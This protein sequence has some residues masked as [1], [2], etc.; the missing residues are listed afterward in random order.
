MNLNILNQKKTKEKENTKLLEGILKDYLNDYFE[1]VE[2]DYNFGREGFTFLAKEV[3]CRKDILKKFGIPLELSTG[4]IKVI[5]LTVKSLITLK[6]FQMEVSDIDI[7]IETIHINKDY[8]KN[9][10]LYRQK[11]LNEWEI[12]HKK[13]FNDMTKNS[14]LEKFIIDRLIPIKFDI[15]NI[16]IT[17]NDTISSKKKIYQI[18]LKIENIHSFG[19]NQN[20]KEIDSTEND[21]IIYRVFDIKGLSLKINKIENEKN[22]VFL[23][24]IISDLDLNIKG[25][26]LQTYKTHSLKSTPKISATT[27]F[28]SPLIINLTIQNINILQNLVNYLT[29]IKK[30]EQYWIN[31]PEFKEEGKL[32]PT[33]SLKWFLYAFRVLRNEIRNNKRQKHELSSLIEKI[34][35]MEKYIQFYKE[36]HKLIIAPWIHQKDH[37]VELINLENK[38]SFDDIIYCR[39]LAFV[40][41]LTEGRAFCASGEVGEGYKPF[42]H[43]WEFYVNDLRTKW[44]NKEENDVKTIKLSDNERRE[45]MTIWKNDRD[46]ILMSY[47]KGEPNHPFDI[48]LDCSIEFKLITLNFMKHVDYYTNDTCKIA[49]KNYIYFYKE[50]FYKKLKT[51]LKDLDFVKINENINDEVIE[52]CIKDEIKIDNNLDSD[53]DDINMENSESS[54]SHEVRSYSNNNV[55]K[56]NNFY[57]KDSS[58]EDSVIYIDEI[59]INKFDNNNN[60]N[61]NNINNNIN[62]NNDSSFE[63]NNN[64]IYQTSTKIKKL[65][66]ILMK[67]KQKETK[68]VFKSIFSIYLFSSNLSFNSLRNGKSELH[69]TIGAFNFLDHNLTYI[70]LINLEKKGNIKNKLNKT[71]KYYKDTNSSN[72]DFDLNSNN[73]N[74]IIN[75]SSIYNAK[76]NTFIDSIS[77]FFIDILKHKKLR[78]RILEDNFKDENFF[79]NQYEDYFGFK[80]CEAQG[81]GITTL[82][83]HYDKIIVDYLIKLNIFS[84]TKNKIKKFINNNLQKKKFKE[85]KEEEQNDLLKKILIK[86]YNKTINYENKRLYDPIVQEKFI[87]TM[88]SDFNKMFELQSINVILY[89]LSE[90]YLFYLHENKYI[91]CLEKR[92]ESIQTFESLFLEINVNK[93]GR[94]Y[95]NFILYKFEENNRKESS[96]TTNDNTNNN[97]DFKNSNNIENINVNNNNN[98]HENISNINNNIN[99]DNNNNNNDNDNPIIQITGIINH[100]IKIRITNELISEF[101]TLQPE[102]TKYENNSYV[103]NIL[104]DLTRSYLEIFDD[105]R[106]LKVKRKV[107]EELFKQFSNIKNKNSDYIYN[108]DNENNSENN[109]DENESEENESEEN[110]N[111]N[112]QND[113]NYSKYPIEMIYLDNITQYIKTLSN[114]QTKITFCFNKEL[115]LSYNLNIHIFDKIYFLEKDKI[116]CCKILLNDIEF[117]KDNLVSIPNKD[118]KINLPNNF[119]LNKI[120]KILFYKEINIGEIIITFNDNFPI[121]KTDFNALFINSLI[122]NTL[123]VSDSIIDAHSNNLEI[124]IYPCVFQLIKIFSNL[125]YFGLIYKMIYNIQKKNNDNKDKNNHWSIIENNFD[126]FTNNVYNIYFNKNQNDDLS[127]N[128]NNNN[129]SEKSSNNQKEVSFEENNKIKPL[130]Y[131]LERRAKSIINYSLGKS[132]KENKGIIVNVFSTDKLKKNIFSSSTNKNNINNNIEPFFN[133]KS[134]F[135]IFH[136]FRNLFFEKNEIWLCPIETTQNYF[137]EKIS[138]ELNKSKPLTFSSN[139]YL[140]CKNFVN[141]VKENIKIHNIL[142]K[143]YPFDH[144]CKIEG[145]NINCLFNNTVYFYELDEK[146]RKIYLENFNVLLDENNIE[147]DSMYFSKM[148]IYINEIKIICQINKNKDL[149]DLY[150]NALKIFNESSCINF[151]NYFNEKV[152]KSLIIENNMKKKININKNLNNENKKL[153]KI[154]ISDQIVK[155]N[156]MSV[157]KFY[158]EIIYKNLNNYNEN[159]ISNKNNLESENEEEEF[160]EKENINNENTK[161]LGFKLNIENIKYNE[162]DTKEKQNNNKKITKAKFLIDNFYLN[163]TVPKNFKNEKDFFDSENRIQIND[164]NKILEIF[165]KMKNNKLYKKESIILKFKDF[166]MKLLGKTTV[167]ISINNFFKIGFLHNNKFE[168]ILSFIPFGLS[169]EDDEQIK[170]YNINEIEID[171]NFKKSFQIN[172]TEILNKNIDYEIFKFYDSSPFSSFSKMI[173]IIQTTFEYKLFYQ[174]NIYFNVLLINFPNRI[175]HYIYYLKNWLRIYSHMLNKV[176]PEIRQLALNNK[177]IKNKIN[178]I[179]NQK[180]NDEID[181]FPENNN[182]N[183][184]IDVP[185]KGAEGLIAKINLPIIFFNLSQDNKEFSNFIFYK[186]EINLIKNDNNEIILN[187]NIND[188]N[189]RVLDCNCKN[190]IIKNKNFIED[191]SNN[192]IIQ[193]EIII[194]DSNS[195]KNKKN[196]QNIKHKKKITLQNCSL[197]GLFKYINEVTLFLDTNELCLNENPLKS[198][199]FNLLYKEKQKTEDY[200]FELNNLHIIIPESS[201]SANYLTIFFKKANVTIN[202]LIDE[203]KTI[204]IPTSKDQIIYVID[205]KSLYGL[206]SEFIT[207]ENS[208]FEINEQQKKFFKEKNS[209]FLFNETIVDVNDMEIISK[210]DNFEK[211]FGIIGKSI[212]FIHNLKS[213]DVVTRLYEYFFKKNKQKNIQMKTGMNVNLYDINANI[214]MSDIEVINHFVDNNIDEKSEIFPEEDSIFNNIDLDI[215]LNKNSQINLDMFKMFNNFFKESNKLEKI[216]EKLPGYNNEITYDTEFSIEDED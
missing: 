93:K 66:T 76:T 19:S 60:N 122:K 2:F 74:N 112:N 14:L 152:F 120:C 163:L 65:N 135:V 73:N 52:K 29:K 188:F 142:S 183:V 156:E 45:L 57:E 133:F 23:G 172:F 144:V 109:S 75:N 126:R 160:E 137:Y 107:F 201:K 203:L 187:I 138:I 154:I 205:K 106:K 159:N 32:N 70:T 165:K 94:E 211:N 20:W 209:L 103:G 67:K 1:N 3:E 195:L 55:S 124:N 42:V 146:L 80:K 182:N 77:Y 4:K 88:V 127:N 24:T 186:N 72:F 143:N 113:N 161:Y 21:D 114:Q 125:N 81:T 84:N 6:N 180:K 192:N 199:M 169:K 105:F 207:I 197:V 108:N 61:N 167:N 214:T 198:D 38:M 59:K 202:N 89:V 166:S 104:N 48:L 181:N 53:D 43:L 39:E 58:A 49:L 204:N 34:I 121:I 130:Q 185:I 111:K 194:D 33:D 92:L 193:M 110:N 158:F 215:K 123:F 116:S 63:N 40:E 101:Q 216:K 85:I 129:N 176:H 18:L 78:E 206:Q 98:N 79:F 37:K 22:Y 17:I 8:K 7:K 210:I 157:N 30:V 139:E 136:K 117:K 27:V 68:N 31:R 15:H 12:K 99:F 184:D 134:N 147:K 50:K 177:N 51:D 91:N 26:I 145:L 5:K 54:K 162:N 171:K 64:E 131:Y 164:L 132:H 13:I 150:F 62:I 141:S 82:K 153:K 95:P 115:N 170:K 128:N 148:G 16:R 44:M 196:N 46:Q 41:L 212:F 191:N 9:Y 140:F 86:N 189:W 97:S 213:M 155:I 47:I 69:F 119:D 11:Q 56:D 149:I 190:L 173:Y 10:Y 200:F 25:K 118:I 87:K 36:S 208:P 151:I 83:N 90:S 102:I 178:D 71:I 96:A 179:I 168:N 28:N 175:Y 35:T 100:P 174:C